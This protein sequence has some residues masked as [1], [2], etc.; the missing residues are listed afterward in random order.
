MILIATQRGHLFPLDLD[1]LS[2]QSNTSLPPLYLLCHFPETQN[3]LLPLP[4]SFP[5]AISF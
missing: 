4:F 5:P 2:H 3:T 1:S